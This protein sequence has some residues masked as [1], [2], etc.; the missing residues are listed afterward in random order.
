MRATNAD[1][2]KPGDSI[3]VTSGTFEGFTGIVEGSKDGDVTI[4]ITIFGRPTPIV[5]TPEL[6]RLKGGMTKTL[7]CRECD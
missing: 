6:L 1:D 4:I 7:K 5:V 2:F 3:T